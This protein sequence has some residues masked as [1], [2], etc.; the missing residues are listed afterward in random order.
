MLAFVV[1]GLKCVS[2]VGESASAE[3]VGERVRS[4][5]AKGFYKLC[6]GVESGGGGYVWGRTDG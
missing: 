3:R 5:G 4:V 1:S 2:Q 6:E